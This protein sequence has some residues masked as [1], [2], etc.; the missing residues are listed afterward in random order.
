M[1]A[2]C[3]QSCA[4]HRD[5]LQLL[6]CCLLPSA[7]CS[8]SRTGAA[9]A[10]TDSSGPTRPA[11]TSTL[12]AAAVRANESIRSAPAV[13]SRLTARLLHCCI[14]RRR[15]VDWISARCIASLLPM[16]TH[17]EMRESLLHSTAV[18][19][20]RTAPAARRKGQPTALSWSD[21]R[22]ALAHRHTALTPQRQGGGDGQMCEEGEDRRHQRH[23]MTGAANG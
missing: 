5:R 7:R 14:G 8:Q 12:E 1:P 13:G 15:L 6:R 9:L 11:V 3:G 22:S 16:P 18:I 2:G 19:E 17:I 4:R 23:T 20:H 21:Q 10:V